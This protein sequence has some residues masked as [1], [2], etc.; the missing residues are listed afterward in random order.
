[1]R[2]LRARAIPGVEA[3]QD[4]TYQ[5][6]I[7]T[8]GFP[9]VIEA[10]PSERG[11]WLDVTMHLATLGSIIDEVQRVRSLFRLDDDPGEAERA[12]RRDPVLGRLVRRRPGTRLPGAWDRFETAVRIILGQQVSVA[13]ASTLSGRIASRFGTELDLDLPGGL[14]HA[15]PT[16]DVLAEADLARIGIPAARARTIRALSRVLATGE[17]DLGRPVLLEDACAELEAIPGVGP[18]TSH[19][20]AARAMGH[21]DAFAAS[22]LGLR[23]AAAVL[24]G[25]PEPLSPKVLE[26]LAEAW[27]PHRTTAMAYLWMSS[28]AEL[29]GPVRKS[30]LAGIRRELQ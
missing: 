27:R 8:C 30:Q 17:L 1:M 21:A 18:W 7:I 23:K 4:G 24:L 16:A 15:F 3:V 26:S 12:L 10:H 11:D 29:R 2:Y 6:L 28:S 14:T 9:G 25:E 22:D 5:R 13:G 20:I 19:L